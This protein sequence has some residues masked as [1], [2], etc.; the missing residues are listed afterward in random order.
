MSET[1][2]QVIEY[3]AVDKKSDKLSRN[4]TY[5]M[6]SHVIITK[7]VYVKICNVLKTGHKKTE[8]ELLHIF[9]I[10]N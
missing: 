5:A 9:G 6:A 3:I 4:S 10:L 7:E 8:H 1:K 2:H